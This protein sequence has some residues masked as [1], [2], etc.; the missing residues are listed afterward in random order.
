M[1]PLRVALNANQYLDVENRDECLNLVSERSETAGTK[2][3][4]RAAKRAHSEKQVRMH[5]AN[6]DAP[7]THHVN[8]KFADMSTDTPGVPVDMEEN[9][10]RSRHPY[11]PDPSPEDCRRHP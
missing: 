11:Y 3:C 2:I 7:H 1:T 4:G 9:V 10:G 8:T 6:V 5:G